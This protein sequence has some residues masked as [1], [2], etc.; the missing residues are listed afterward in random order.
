MYILPHIQKRHTKKEDEP[1]IHRRGTSNGQDA[2]VKNMYID[3]YED[4]TLNFKMGEIR[5]F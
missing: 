5:M 1:A 4:S 2:W 3:N